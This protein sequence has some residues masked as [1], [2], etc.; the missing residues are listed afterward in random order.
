MT[1]F[2]DG[3]VWL[4]DPA[5]WTGINAIPTRVAEHLWYSAAALAVAGAIALPAGLWVGH[6]RRYAGLV[7]TTGN[8]GRAVPDLG[9]V[10]L[11]AVLIGFGVLPV[12]LALIALAIP[13]VL[14]NT[15]TGVREVDPQ[16]RDAAEGMGFSGWQLLWRVEAPLALPLV[17]AG[18]RTSTVQ[19][20][21]TA[22]IAGF[23]GQ[24]G[25]LGRYIFDG[26]ALQDTARVV[27]GAVL[28]ALLAVAADLALGR[29]QRRA[30]PRGL[31]LAQAMPEAGGEG[32]TTTGQ[33][34]SIGRSASAT[35]GSKG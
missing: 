27:G 35:E 5:N 9:I 16:V 12:I 26:I 33:P 19:V 7:V 1:F 24:A 25:G 31:A 18:L 22:T 28:C 32:P 30:L 14:T 6:T 3:L 23:I 8:L 29:A 15:Y 10:A 2:L 17:F 34:A 21:A 20:I 13:P 4:A 11:A